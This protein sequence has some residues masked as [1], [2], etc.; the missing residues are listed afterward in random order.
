MMVAAFVGLPEET[1]RIYTEAIRKKYKFYS[2]GD[3]MFIK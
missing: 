2:F 1:L 3:A